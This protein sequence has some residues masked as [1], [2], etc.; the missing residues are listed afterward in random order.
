[1]RIGAYSHAAGKIEV[2]A[3]ID[4]GAVDLRVAQP[5]HFGVHKIFATPK[6]IGLLPGS[7]ES[8]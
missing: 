8:P 3:A 6:E 4:A 1:M 7:A 2:I 5:S